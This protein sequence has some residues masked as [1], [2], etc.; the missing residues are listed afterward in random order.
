VFVLL[1]A[2]GSKGF[3]FSGW[4]SICSLLF[5]VTRYICTWRTY[6][7]ETFHKY[8]T[9]EWAFLKRLLWSVVKGQG[10]NYIHT[11][12]CECYTSGSIH[13]YSMASR[14]SRS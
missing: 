1:P 13:F 14:L 8:S 4:L 7:S 12:I 11:Q 6:F 2:I 9:F 3:M 10:R 5:C